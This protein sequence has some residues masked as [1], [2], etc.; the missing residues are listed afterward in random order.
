MDYF[1]RLLMSRTNL[2]IRVR[3][4]GE[5]P[6][7]RLELDHSIAADLPGFTDRYILDWQPIEKEDAYFGNIRERA[8]L[9][10]VRSLQDA[11]QRQGWEEGTTQLLELVTEHLDVGVTTSQVCGFA[12]VDGVKRHV[13][14]LVVTKVEQVLRLSAIFDYVE[15]TP[16]DADDVDPNAQQ[17]PKMPGGW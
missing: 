11:Y 14:R 13:R 17:V 16:E 1:L 3:Q 10:E 2:T 8:R 6:Q 7:T 4:S 5:G 9:T 12:I 15:Y